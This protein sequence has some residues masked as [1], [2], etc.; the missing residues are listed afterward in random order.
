MGT[1]TVPTPLEKTEALEQLRALE[2][3][4]AIHCFVTA[5]RGFGVD[6]PEDLARAEQMLK[7]MT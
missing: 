7:T 4:I 5:Y 2:N 3:G 6:T 1:S